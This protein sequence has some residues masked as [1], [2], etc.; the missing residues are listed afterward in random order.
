MVSRPF[1]QQRS[2]LVWNH[3]GCLWLPMVTYSLLMVAWGLL[4]DFLAIYI[5][6]S[7]EEVIHIS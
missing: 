1:M 5:R 2:D 3:Y 6:I 7:Y 4:V